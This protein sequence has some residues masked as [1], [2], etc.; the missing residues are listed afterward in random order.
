MKIDQNNA[1]T[2]VEMVATLVV[3]S[4]LVFILSTFINMSNRSYEKTVRTSGANTSLMYG[5]KLM[6][7]R[8][9]KS[10]SLSEVAAS[11]QWLSERLICDNYAFG[12]YQANAGATKDLVYLPDKTDV[13]NREVILAVPSTDPLNF[14]VTITGTGTVAAVSVT[15]TMNDTAFTITGT[16]MRRS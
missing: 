8:V 2:L 11:G 16:M 13:N 3:G 7:S 5:L 12:V 6:Q 4:L 1:V 15:G 14:A 9:H 10:K